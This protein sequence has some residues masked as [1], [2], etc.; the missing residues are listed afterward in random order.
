MFDIS[1]NSFCCC[2]CYCIFCNGTGKQWIFRI[3]FKITSGKCASMNIHSRC[4]PS[5]YAHLICH[6][7]DTGSKC[8]G[9]IHIPC[10]GNHYS[11]RKSNGSFSG[12]VIINGCR[13]VTVYCLY[14]SDLFYRCCLISAKCNQRI[15]ITYRQFIQQF[16][17]FGILIIQT[18]KISQLHAIF[19]SGCRHLI[20]IIVFCFR[21]IITI[22]KKCCFVFLRH[23][24][25]R[26]CCC[27]IFIICKMICT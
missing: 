10:V 23:C 24:I 17:P 16:I 4:I 22:V 11:C 7:T 18:T 1:I 5:G 12:K 21:I 27:C 26:R 3:I 19:G 15:H 13:S 6:F 14:L 20:R 2:T 9:K 8:S 25:I